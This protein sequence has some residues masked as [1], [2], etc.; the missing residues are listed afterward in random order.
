M[1]DPPTPAEI[2]KRQ[3]SFWARQRAFWDKIWASAPYNSA[4]SPPPRARRTEAP[5]IIKWLAWCPNIPTEDQVVE[6]VTFLN[7]PRPHYLDPSLPRLS[8]LVRVP[9]RW[10]GRPSPSRNTVEMAKA[11][12]T[13]AVLRAGNPAPDFEGHASPAQKTLRLVMVRYEGRPI[14]LDWLRSLLRYRT[15][16]R[17]RK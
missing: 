5:E 6:L 13:A 4:Y 9:G 1:A 2:N 10:V 14:R 16:Q 15:G 11:L 3:Q 17:R 8:R 12:I 7:Q